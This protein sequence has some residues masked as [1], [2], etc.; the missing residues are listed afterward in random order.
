MDFLEAEM[1]AAWFWNVWLEP[2]TVDSSAAEVS[3]M[4]LK[5]AGLM[6][7]LANA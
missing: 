2:I 5:V 3:G 7:E 4:S 1:R 6:T